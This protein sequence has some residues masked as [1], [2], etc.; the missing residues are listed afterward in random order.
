[1]LLSLF[2]FKRLSEFGGAITCVLARPNRAKYLTM[3]RQNEPDT[4]L[5][6]AIKL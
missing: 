3:A 2:C 4:Q 1:M 6:I 5:K